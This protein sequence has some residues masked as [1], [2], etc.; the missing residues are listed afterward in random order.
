MTKYR[1]VDRMTRD[2]EKLYFVRALGIYFK[3]EHGSPLYGTLAK[4][5]SV[6]LECEVTKSFV[7][8]NLK[9]S[10]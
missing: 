3:K 6:V 8:K 10:Q 9:G 5:A 1:V 2:R 4:T 7:T